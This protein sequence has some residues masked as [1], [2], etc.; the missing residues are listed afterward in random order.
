VPFEFLPAAT[1]EAVALFVGVVPVVLVE[2]AVVVL[3]LVVVPAVV[4]DPGAGQDSP[5]QN[6]SISMNR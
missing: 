5:S 6:W 1:R 2:L 3:L 4:A